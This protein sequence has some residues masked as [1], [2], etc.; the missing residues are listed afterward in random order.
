MGNGE[1]K[2]NRMLNFILGSVFV[3]LLGLTGYLVNDMFFSENILFGT[4][5]IAS[6]VYENK[7]KQ[8]SQL[9]KQVLQEHRSVYG[10]S[11]IF[12]IDEIE[13]MVRSKVDAGSVDKS[14]LGKIIFNV[15]RNSGYITINDDCNS[16]ASGLA[17]LY[18]RFGIEPKI[19]TLNNHVFLCFDDQGKKVYVD[20]TNGQ[21]FD[22]DYYKK[23]TQGV[24]EHDLDT[25]LSFIY[26][27]K[28]KILLDKFDIHQL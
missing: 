24:Q 5:A 7:K 18:K 12:N 20:P 14:D 19:M 4:K 25:L 28:A 26:A 3:S 8:M 13:D 9:E 17:M 23:R 6:Q 27:D 15:F 10:S 21:G 2:G 16:L 22:T 11:A 1:Y